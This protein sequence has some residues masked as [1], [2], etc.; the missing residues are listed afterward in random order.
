M[1][2]WD[3]TEDSRGLLPLFAGEFVRG[4]PAQGF[5]VFGVVT[6]QDKGLQMLVQLDGGFVVKTL[7]RRFLEGAILALDL[8]VGPGRSGFG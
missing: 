2:I 7:D 4:E 5:E 8:A 6:G 1:V 3:L